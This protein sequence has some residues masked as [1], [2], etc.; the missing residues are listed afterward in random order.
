MVKK[1]ARVT[2][3][4]V[5]DIVSKRKAI[6]REV[7]KARVYYDKVGGYNA[8]YPLRL[9]EKKLDSYNTRLAKLGYNPDGISF[10]KLRK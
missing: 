4:K 3:K 10:K 1:Q 7:D 5:I 9:L 6:Q 2:P 8:R